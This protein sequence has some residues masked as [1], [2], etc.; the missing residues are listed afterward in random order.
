MNKIKL[1]VTTTFGLESV[2]KKELI[3]LGFDNFIVSDGKIEFDA[4]KS[5]I[6]KLNLSLRAADRVLV[7]MGEFKATDF[8]LLFDQTKAL[9]WNNWIT[10]DG[11]ITV[12]GKSVKSSLRSVRANQS[13]VKKAI[14]ENM[15]E[16]FN[17]EIFPETGPEFIIKVS[18]LKN[19]AQLTIDTSGVGLHKRGYRIDTGD[20]PIRENLAAGL[21]L[22]S[23][24]NRGKVLID[25]MCGS[26]TI[27]IEAAM[28]GRNIAPGLNRNFI[29]EDWPTLD[30]KFWEDARSFAHAAIRPTG[31]LKVFGYDIDKERIEGCK[32]NAKNAGVLEDIVFKQQDIKD[33]KVECENG[34]LIS[35]PPYGVKMALER[36]FNHIY[37][38]INMIFADK[39]GWGV[40]IITA[41]KNFPNSFKQ[42]KPN[43]VRKLYNG[44]IEVNYYQYRR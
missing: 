33:L 4:N 7:K 32:A 9:P 8:D 38:P 41:D 18:I 10:K 21:I 34:M 15:Q 19:I 28:I 37:G 40:Y 42:A 13:I 35:N 44:T 6:P 20:V 5:D 23:F 26:G 36:G 22:L 3:T 11:K 31:D 12:I 39:P 1:I 2:V 14:I 24:Y 27:L 16:V 30:K 29:S 25:P 17:K 43:K